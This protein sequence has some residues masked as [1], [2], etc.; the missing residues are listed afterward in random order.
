M[1][2]YLRQNPV[3]VGEGKEGDEYIVV[4]LDHVQPALNIV[5]IYGENEKR[6]GELRILESWLRLKNDL[7]EIKKTGR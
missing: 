2:S 4:R 3:K 6:A 1:A 5:N 7:E